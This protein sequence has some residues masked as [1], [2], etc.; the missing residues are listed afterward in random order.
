MRKEVNLGHALW[1]YTHCCSVLIDLTLT[2]FGLALCSTDSVLSETLRLTAAALITREVVKDKQLRLASGQEYH[3]RKG[4][5]VCL[6][7]FLSPQMDP[8]IHQDPQVQDTRT[9][10]HTCRELANRMTRLSFNIHFLDKY[11]SLL[12]WGEQI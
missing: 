10:T 8:K 11:I 2:S 4:D 6:F 9:Y 3:L 7:P 5:K 1:S 12:T